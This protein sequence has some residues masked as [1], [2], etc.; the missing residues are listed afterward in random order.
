MQTVDLFVVKNIW[1]SVVS[2]ILELFILNAKHGFFKLFSSVDYILALFLAHLF[3]PFLAM[4]CS[5]YIKVICKSLDI[6]Y[7]KIVRTTL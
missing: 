2:E 6:K 4:K 1:K 3:V 5:P 7:S